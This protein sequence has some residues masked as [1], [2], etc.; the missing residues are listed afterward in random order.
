MSYVVTLVKEVSKHKTF[1]L[2]GRPEMPICE[3]AVGKN[4]GV[5]KALPEPRPTSD[6]KRN[7]FW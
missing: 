7:S 1:I 4:G 5:G 6:C 2:N 3:D